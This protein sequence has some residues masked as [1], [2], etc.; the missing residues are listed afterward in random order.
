MMPSASYLLTLNATEGFLQVAIGG[1]PE[2]LVREV[3]HTSFTQT[4]SLQSVLPH[5]ASTGPTVEKEEAKKLAE[6]PKTMT[7]AAAAPAPRFS[8]AKVKKRGG[9]VLCAQE[10][11]LPA[12]GAELL[13]PVLK[14]ITQQLRIDINQISHIACVVGPGSFTGIRLITTSAAGLSQATGAKMGG[15]PYM[16]LLARNAFSLLGNVFAPETI[17]WVVT[18]ARRNL[19]HAQ[20]FMLVA[21]EST[22]LPESLVKEP[23]VKGPVAK[24]TPMKEFSGEEWPCTQG[25]MVGAVVRA[26]SAIHVL[27]LDEL[28]SLTTASSAPCVLLGSGITRNKDFLEKGYAAVSPSPVILGSLFDSPQASILFEMACEISFSHKE[29]SPY[30]VRA[31]DAEEALADIAAKLGLNTDAALSAYGALQKD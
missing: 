18:H 30:Y 26:V 23:S 11:R 28:I 5:G 2:A 3:E 31:S 15:I 7:I 19:V 4:P 17:F 14:N 6:T 27:S 25:S 22:P 8:G 13:A 16:S 9:G 1:A 12:Q 20:G 24:K 21:S 29:L 10:W